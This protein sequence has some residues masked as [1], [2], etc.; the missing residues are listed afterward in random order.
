MEL[1]YIAA[2]ACVCNG[3]KVKIINKHRTLVQITEVRIYTVSE[4][5]YTHSCA[6]VTAGTCWCL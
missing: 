5:A 3:S 2:G 4:G 1:G 6:A